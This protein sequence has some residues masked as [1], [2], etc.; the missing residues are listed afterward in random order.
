MAMHETHES[1]PNA[2]HK[3]KR[4]SFSNNPLQSIVA[5]FQARTRDQQGEDMDRRL[6][7]HAGTTRS[8]A[9]RMCLTCGGSCAP[10]WGSCGMVDRR[11]VYG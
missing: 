2:V 5:Q 11:P 8:T 10:S 7:A 4:N 6:P 9:Q 1:W 3:L